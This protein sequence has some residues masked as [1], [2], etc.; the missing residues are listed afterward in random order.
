MTFAVCFGPIANS[1][2]VIAAD[3][4]LWLCADLVSSV[5]L[6]TNVVSAWRDNSGQGSDFASPNTQSAPSYVTGRRLDFDGTKGMGSA[7]LVLNTDAFILFIAFE[8]NGVAVDYPLISI[9]VNGV[10]F[11]VA[12]HSSSVTVSYNSLLNTAKTA[13][14]DEMPFGHFLLTIQMTNLMTAPT[15]IIRSNG[16]DKATSVALPRGASGSAKIAYRDIPLEQ[17]F[18]GHIHEIVL[19]DRNISDDDRYNTENLLIDKWSL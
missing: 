17:R 9:P 10:Q 11:D 18:V 12:L 15:T 2:Q 5:E 3:P 7:D 8:K 1:R 13:A 19:Y 16:V 6:N 14:I 4:A